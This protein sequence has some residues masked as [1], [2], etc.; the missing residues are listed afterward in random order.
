MNNFKQMVHIT[1]TIFKNDKKLILWAICLTLITTISSNLIIP[2]TMQNLFDA[3][4]I[5]DIQNLYAICKTAVICMII[6]MMLSFT[7]HVY[8]DAWFVMIAN[9]GISVMTKDL[10][11]LPYKKLSDNFSEGELINRIGEGGISS[12]HVYNVGIRLSATL[13]SVFGLMLASFFVNGLVAILI[14]IITF[15]DIFRFRYEMNKQLKILNDV[16]TIESKIEE[17]VYNTISNMSFHIMNN[18]LDFVTKKF[19]RFRIWVILYRV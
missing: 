4:Q 13:V 8:A 2:F 18:N 12:T 19:T 6:L 16:K 7:F 9:Q 3:V 17:T 14:I 15:L 5:G 10:Y 11:N 1:N